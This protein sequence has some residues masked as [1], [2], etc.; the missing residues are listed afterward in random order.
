MKATEQIR[1]QWK[2]KRAHGDATR[3]REAFGISITT[4]SR[5]LLSGRGARETIDSINKY[6]GIEWAKKINE[7]TD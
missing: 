5:C 1:K 3:I 6:Y 7:E 4:V 2:I